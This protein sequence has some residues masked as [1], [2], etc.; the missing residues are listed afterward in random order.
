MVPSAENIQMTQRTARHL[1]IRRIV[2]R[3]IVIGVVCLVVFLSA[4]SDSSIKTNNTHSEH[5]STEL[6]FTDADESYW[7]PQPR[8]ITNIKKIEPAAAKAAELNGHDSS[9][10]EELLLVLGDNYAKLASHEIKDKSG[11]SVTVETEYFIYDRNEVLT[12]TVN[13]AD[14]DSISYSITAASDYQPPESQQEVERAITL[15][16]KALSD[17]GYTNHQHLTGTA[18]LAYPTAAELAQ[19]GTRFYSERKLYVTFGPGGGTLPHYRALVNLSTASV[20]QSGS[21]QQ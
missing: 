18:L 5:S 2:A 17:Q 19:S 3:L 16:S 12:T 1:V 8:G 14:S 13:T 21:M 7:P 11:N 15:A 10:S 4:C 6:L 20:E 9:I